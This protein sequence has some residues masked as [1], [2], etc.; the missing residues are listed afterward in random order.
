MNFK[1]ISK[2][3]LFILIVV[4]GVSAQINNDG[5]A[6][7]WQNYR[8]S[9]R[10]LSL[11][12]PKLP[13]KIDESLICLQQIFEKYAAYAGDTIYGVNIVSKLN[14]KVPPFCSQRRE[15]DETSFQTRVDELKSTDKLATVTAVKLGKLNAQFIKTPLVNY[16][17]FNDFERKQWVELWTAGSDE[18]TK[19]VKDFVGSIRFGADS[20]GIEI[21]D[22]SPI[23]LGDLA[24]TNSEKSEK[25]SPDNLSG[26]TNSVKFLIKPPPRYTDLARKN[27]AEGSVML[28]VTFLSN[29]GIGS[30]S[31]ATA[32]PFGLTEAAI[33]AAKKIVFLPARR[34]G[35]KH[36]VTK[37][38]RYTFTIF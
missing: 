20:R 37:A 23:T 31:V 6:V 22:G 33:A 11:Q 1:Q 34:N 17:L 28:R 25:Q 19:T 24:E 21:G 2:T 29:G 8:I 7:K 4:I 15:F 36:S 12:L 26:S 14:E 9:P 13:V 32:L 30:V 5:V 18:S 27:N 10:Q 38:V 35:V 3:V 16:W